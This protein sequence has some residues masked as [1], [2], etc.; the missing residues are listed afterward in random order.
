MF[1]RPRNL[2]YHKIQLNQL[3]TFHVNHS[4]GSATFCVSR[5]ATDAV[6]W[7][8]IRKFATQASQNAG[9]KLKV[10][11]LWT[12]SGDPGGINCGIYQT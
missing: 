1:L 10:D 11:P 7:L 2:R 9:Q 6:S 4:G 3:K 8:L 5:A 12:G